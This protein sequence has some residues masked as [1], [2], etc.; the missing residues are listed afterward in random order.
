MK[1]F[2]WK[3]II[4]LIPNLIAG[5]FVW[6]ATELY[7]AG[8]GGFKLGVDLVGGTILVYEIDQTKE[9]EKA[10][11]PNYRS[12]QG[13]KSQLAAFLKR[14]IDP[15]D[16]YNIVVRMVGV[17]KDRVE[18][19]LPTGGQHRSKLAQEAWD[20]VIREVKADPRFAALKN[21]ADV[22]DVG[23]GKVEELADRIKRRLE[24]KK[25]PKLLKAKEPW[26]ALL[27]L[28]KGF[29]PKEE[30][31]QF[32]KIP[33][34]HYEQ[35]LSRLKNYRKAVDQIKSLAQTLAWK[36]TL[37]QLQKEYPKAGKLDPDKFRPEHREELVS[38][39]E[40]NGNP[41]RQAAVVSVRPLFPA[42]EKAQRIGDR[43]DELYGP[44]QGEVVAA[45]RKHYKAGEKR[46]VTTEE[47][48][49]IKDLI[50]HVGRLEFLILANDVDDKENVVGQGGNGPDDAD[51]YL[52]SIGASKLDQYA[53]D[54]RPPPGPEVNGKPKIYEIRTVK[55][56]TS[57][58]GYRWV[59]LGWNYRK[60]LGLSNAGAAYSSPNDTWGIVAQAREAARTNRRDQKWVAEIPDSRGGESNGKLYIYSRECKD[61]NL[62]DEK[63]KDKKYEYFVLARTADIAGPND[64][65]P[66]GTPKEVTGDY[67]TSARRDTDKYAKPCVD[68]TFN[69]TGA[70]LFRDLTGKNI[71]DESRNPPFY[72]HLAIVL[73]G[74]VMSAPTINS[75][76]GANGQITGG[77]TVEE[78]DRLVNT[79]RSGALP[80]TLKPQPVSEN[81]MGA[82]LG[83]DT[84]RSGVIAVGIAFAAVLI[85]M[86]IY[87]RFA[88]LVACTAL[89]SNLLLTVGFMV[90]VQA[91]FTLPG[92]AG[93]VLMLGM[94]VDANVLIYERLR[95][96]RDRGASLALAIRNGYDRAFPTIIDTHLTSIFTA[97]VLYVVGNDQLKGF[98]VSLTVGLIISLFTSLYMTR[99]IFDIWQSK[100]WLKKLGMFRLLS[101]TNIDFMAIR[102]YWFT[103]TILLTLLGV[104]IFLLRGEQ[105][106]NIDFVGGTA[107]GGKLVEGK[108]LQELRGLFGEEE[109]KEKLKVAKVKQVGDDR[110]TYEI[111][112]APFPGSKLPESRT[113]YINDPKGDS[114]GEREEDVRRRAEQL[115]DWS[116]EQVF[117]TSDKEAT[118]DKSRYFTVRTPEKEAQLVQASID[119]LLQVPGKN[120][121]GKWV[122]LLDKVDMDYR[123][124]PPPQATR[125]FL[126]FDVETPKDEPVAEATLVFSDYASPSFVTTVLEQSLKDVLKGGS[127]AADREAASFTLTGEGKSQE[128]H[129][130]A[131]NLTLAN[132]LPRATLQR[133]L[134]KTKDVFNKRP[135]P[136]RLENF[137]SALA[138]ETQ[139]RAIGAIVLSWGAILLYLWLR[140]GSWTFGLA[141]VLCLIHDLFFTLGL[142]ALG[143]YLH[144]TPVGRWLMLQDFKLDLTAVAALLTLVGYSVSDTIVV[145]DRIREVRGKNPELTP[146]MINDSVNQTLSRTLLT[147]FSVW[148][149]VSVLYIFGGQ[150]VHLFAYVMVIGVIVGT[151]SS[152]YIASPLLL[153]FGEGAKKTAPV[154]QR[155]PQPAQSPA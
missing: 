31:G 114:R 55:G 22:F 74:Q 11:D 117:L 76:I 5:F 97:I 150:G 78:V 16:L 132:G 88:G 87:Y 75:E 21:D 52:K 79:L 39:I 14:R 110:H 73:D 145:F 38:F 66:A 134:E 147:A 152:I 41:F 94:A 8:E 80:A 37:K 44:S 154:R 6:R 42:D 133:V 151:Y 17:G 49:R 123:L 64:W 92:L 15:N 125:S 109:Q 58:V 143:S 89:L 130:K 45:I 120:R 12:Q 4:C 108:T 40:G 48:Q 131:M 107:Y 116:V 7:M 106:L 10:K 18:I 28:A 128:S 59:E 98:G 137:D 24:E 72:R 136:E 27:N 149:V 50:A 148:L 93:L 43:I 83:Q 129:F 9:F 63:R 126:W 33:P 20:R 2:V 118:N 135:Q 144:A 146:Q 81:T 138:A 26:N 61:Q 90:A 46:D 127:S 100:G 23:Q 101:R 56:K 25:W 95:E 121:P 142:I 140:F 70:N 68:F 113:V 60:Q 51:E 47:V 91:T 119:R 71:P 30:A 77:F 86:V 155:E 67:L 69:A 122:S 32:D 84:I 103:A 96:E 111:T 53:K 153:I 65:L 82:T 85:F 19:I 3:I 29:V 1:P 54:G 112:Y 57:R 99:L 141:A 13:D 105:G 62:T 34:G 139:G 36:E 102:Y 115:P 35:L 124:P 104:T